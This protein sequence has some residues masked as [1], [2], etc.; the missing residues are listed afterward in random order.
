MPAL[1]ERQVGKGLAAAPGSGSWQ[2][3][4]FYGLGD[5]VFLLL[6]RLLL[7]GPSP[8]AGLGPGLAFAA[9]GGSARG[10]S[11]GWRG[12]WGAG[13]S[14][15][16]SSGTPPAACHPS[17]AVLFLRELRSSEAPGLLGGGI[18]QTGWEQCGL[19]V[20]DRGQALRSHRRQLA[21]PWTLSP[22]LCRRELEPS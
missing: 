20:F 14:W 4:C 1:R 22:A 21:E 7:L 16:H 17:Q 11:A 2:R 18:P 6:F 5:Y 13:W 19:H 8:A 9:A 3:Y 12:S 15:L 10:P